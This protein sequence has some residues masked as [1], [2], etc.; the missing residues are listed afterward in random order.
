MRKYDILVVD[1]TPS[2]VSLLSIIL[3]K[4]IECEL[5]VAFDG[6]SAI[7]HAREKNPNLIL[8]DWQMPGIDGIRSVE[9]LQEDPATAHIP[10][11]MITCFSEK[12]DLEIAFNAGVVDYITKPFVAIELL[13]RVRASLKSYDNYQQMIESQKQEVKALSIKNLQNEEFRQKYVDELKN[14]K[15]VAQNETESIV[16]LIDQ[17]IKD[18]NADFASNFW[19]QIENR[20]RESDPVFFKHLGERHSNLTPAEHRL[21]YF[22]RLNLSTK[23]IAKIIFQSYDSV[24]IA[25]TRLRKKLQINSEMTL[26]AYLNSF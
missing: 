14:I 21:C 22:L 15:S 7:K 18:M 12:K 5:S 6:V 1:D 25:R 3:S 2:S 24:R 13:A 9:I 10:I 20:V 17:I 16:P 4:N 8:M 26:V 23:E 11:I 19:F